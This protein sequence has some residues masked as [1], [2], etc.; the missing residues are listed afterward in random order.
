MFLN[1]RHFRRAT[2]LAT[3]LALAAVLVASCARETPYGP[4]G[5]GRSMGYSDQQIAE[6]R[7]RVQFSGNSATPRETV[8]NYLLYRAAELTLKSGYS[9]FVFDTRDTE[10]K[11][12]YRSTFD[13]WPRHG[14]YWHSWPYGYGWPHPAG[15]A[16]VEAR[17]VTR[18]TAYAEIVL[19]HEAEAGSGPAAID[20]A[21]VVRRIGPFVT[22]PEAP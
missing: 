5:H 6:N 3:V 15:L 12:Y 14:W 17:P 9:H 4:A 21:D 10:S 20:A 16:T 22:R 13:A 8:E 18:Y 2:G 19:M 7:Y 11:T 1:L